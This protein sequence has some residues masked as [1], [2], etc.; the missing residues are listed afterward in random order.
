MPI[1]C[2]SSTVLPDLLL[3]DIDADFRNIFNDPTQS[4]EI[5]LVI[6]IMNLLQTDR[7]EFAL[8]RT[9]A[10][11]NAHEFVHHGRAAAKAAGTFRFQLFFREC[12]AQIIEA[13]SCL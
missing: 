1:S 2:I 3:Y 10:A 13:G 6:S 5:L 8:G 7:I 9:D 4:M 11:A 12:A